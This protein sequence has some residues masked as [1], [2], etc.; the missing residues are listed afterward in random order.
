[1]SEL[2]AL[3]MV[4]QEGQVGESLVCHTPVGKHLG[5]RWEYVETA[6]VGIATRVGCQEGR[7]H[8]V[9]AV[10][11]HRSVLWVEGSRVPHITGI[12][13]AAVALL[14]TLL[15]DVEILL[16]LIEVLVVVSV[17]DIPIAGEGCFQADGGNVERAA[18]SCWVAQIHVLDALVVVVCPTHAEINLQIGEGL[19]AGFDLHVFCTG[20]G[21]RSGDAVGHQQPA[22]F[23]CLIDIAVANQSESEIHT[24]AECSSHFLLS[25]HV[26]YI[27]QEARQGEVERVAVGHTYVAQHHQEA[28]TCLSHTIPFLLLP[29]W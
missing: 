19:Q 25:Q 29:F 1:M 13:G 12:G 18:S 10:L 16:E 11:A 14:D 9:A 3:E 4:A 7:D 2:Y 28:C 22:V 15:I 8:H 23:L 17:V 21:S 5:Q 24:R 20:C 27:R 26:A 6:S